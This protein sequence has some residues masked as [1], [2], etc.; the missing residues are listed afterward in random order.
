MRKS[1]FSVLLVF[2]GAWLVTSSEAIEET[3]FVKEVQ[4]SEGPS[5]EQVRQSI[6]SRCRK[7][8]GSYGASIVKFC[9]DEDIEAYQE[10]SEYDDQYQ[11]TIDRCVR[12]ML[13]VGG[14][15]IVK[16]CADEDI[17]AEDALQGY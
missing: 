11:G 12:D 17:E 4:S 10:L 8:M 13:D 7:Q 3:E 15:A 1:I 16:F 5:E 9:V 2:L 6:I 14:W